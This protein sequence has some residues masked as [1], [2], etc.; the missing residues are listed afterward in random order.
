MKMCAKKTYKEF[1]ISAS[2]ILLTSLRVAPEFIYRGY[3]RNHNAEN[4][5]EMGSVSGFSF[6]NIPESKIVSV[7]EAALNN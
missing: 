1:K 4:Q 5:L 2:V 6:A 7:E 3:S